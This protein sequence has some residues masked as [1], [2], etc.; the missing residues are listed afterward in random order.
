MGEADRQRALRRRVQ[1]EGEVDLVGLQVEHRVA[2]GGFDIGELR[3][4]HLGDVLGHLDAGAAPFAGGDVLLEIR[5]FARQRGDAQRLG[6][7][8]AVEGAFVGG[9]RPGRAGQGGGGQQRGSAGQGPAAELGGHVVCLPV[10]GGPDPQSVGPG[11]Q[12]HPSRQATSE[13]G[14]YCIR[15]SREVL[16]MRPHAEARIARLAETETVSFGPLARLQQTDRR[17]RAAD[18]HR[19]ADL[20]AGISNAAALASLC[21][22]PVH[23]R[24]RDGSL[25]GR[26]G[27]PPG[28]SGS[29][30]HDRPARLRAARVPQRRPGRLRLLG[31][32]G[33]PTRI[34]H[35]IEPD[36]TTE[37][38]RRVSRCASA[39]G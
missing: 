30:R 17:R 7:A 12:S 37:A 16:A 4:E 1:R 35:R 36:L 34:V 39:A 25:A 5:Q 18:L 13:R 22:V 6:A 32:H 24:G 9:L 20:Q 38:V 8:D 23:H 15:P 31:I 29:R 33:S 3:V 27:G 11:L 21:R 10:F 26:P 14:A 28:A 2:V 19:C